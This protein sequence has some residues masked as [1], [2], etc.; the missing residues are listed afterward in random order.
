M[1]SVR[2]KEE[3]VQKSENFADVI[4]GSP[5]KVKMSLAPVEQSVEEVFWD[6]LGG[7][8]GR[9]DHAELPQ[10]LLLH[11]LPG[12]V[13]EELAV[14][15]RQATLRPGGKTQVV[16]ITLYSNKIRHAFN[17]YTDTVHIG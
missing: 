8:V 11:L 4:Y 3:G 12:E 16:K 1:N 13:L 5:L 10:D 2:D 7:D 9:G 15:A 14:G 17:L 6:G